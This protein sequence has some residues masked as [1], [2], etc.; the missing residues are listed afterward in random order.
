M[1]NVRFRTKVIVFLKSGSG[2]CV[3]MQKVREQDGDVKNQGGNL[4]IAI[5][6]T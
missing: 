2:I 3:E 4:A 5:E 6:K 1:E